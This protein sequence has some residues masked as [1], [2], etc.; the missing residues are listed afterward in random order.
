MKKNKSIKRK[1]VIVATTPKMVRFF[2]VD[3]ILELSKEYDVTVVSNFSGQEGIL[4]VLTNNINTHNVPIVRSVN[5]Y[6]DIRSLFLLTVFLYKEKFSA[7]YSI[8][9]KGGFLGM[10][11]S[12]F[13]R[14]PVRIHTFTGQVWVSKVGLARYFLKSMD[15]LIAFLATRIIID[16]PSQLEFLSME[17]VVSRNKA[18]VIG[19]G[20]ISGVNKEIFY[21][22]LNVRRMIRSTMNVSDESVIFLFVGR[23]K[24]D[25]GIFELIESFNEIYL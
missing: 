7:L 8:S 13:I 3:H 20:S 2:L 4:D 10:L 25:K 18:V 16:S 11:S 15:K 21:P 19:N 14:I 9:P 23:L 5:I 17:E 1:I 22:D 6:K 24:K 12:I